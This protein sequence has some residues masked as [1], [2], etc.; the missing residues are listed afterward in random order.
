MIIEKEYCLEVETRL[1]IYLF[2]RVCYF[3]CLRVDSKASKSTSLT[4]VAITLIII[5]TWSA[6][7]GDFWQEISINPD[8]VTYILLT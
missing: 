1:I 4:L 3:M 6:K 7:S 2:L 5:S 8:I